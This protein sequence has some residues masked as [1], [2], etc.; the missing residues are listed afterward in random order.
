MNVNKILD[1]M[2]QQKLKLTTETYAALI[3]THAKLNNVAKV[4]EI[5]QHCNLNNIHFSN[6]NILT[7]I[8]ILSGNNN[9]NDVHTV[10]ISKNFVIKYH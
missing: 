10:R 3:Y 6:I 8:Y 1:Y 5:I 2:K 7:V 9:I 4:K